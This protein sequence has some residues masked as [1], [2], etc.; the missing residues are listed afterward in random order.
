MRDSIEAGPS[1]FTVLASRRSVRGYLPE[2]VPQQTLLSDG[3]V[4]VRHPNWD[5][6][7]RLS[8]AAATGIKM[9]AE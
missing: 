4:M 1:F 2:E 8:F 6:A 3:H 9:Y 7:Y 5:E